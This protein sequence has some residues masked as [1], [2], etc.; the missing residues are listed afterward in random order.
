[1]SPQPFTILDA[2]AAPFDY[3][4]VDTDQIIPVRFIRTPRSHGY[5]TMLFRD[6]RFD[7]T[8]NERSQFVLNRAGYRDAGILV[9]NT[10]FG[11]GSSREQAVWALVDYGIRCVIAAS[12]GDIFANNAV[13]HGLLLIREEP[14]VLTETR[15]LLDR[16]SVTRVKVDLDAQSW[17]VDG[18]AARHFEI[19]PARKQK[20]LLGL[21]EIGLTLRFRDDIQ[22]FETEYRSRRSWLFQNVI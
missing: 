19:E 6:L 3:P 21:D 22:R 14:A 20:L 12:F 17:Q 13:N 11:T 4:S 10:D 2:I 15:A 18:L 5:E 7:P 8:G 9:A 16:S 1:V